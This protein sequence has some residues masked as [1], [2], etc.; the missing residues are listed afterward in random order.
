MIPEEGLDVGCG[1]GALTIAC[2][3]RNPKAS[4]IGLDYWEKTISLL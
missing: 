2:A 3:K 4:M 1:S